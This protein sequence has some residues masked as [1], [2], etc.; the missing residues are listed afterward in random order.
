MLRAAHKS[1]SW[2]DERGMRRLAG[3]MLITAF[4]DLESHSDSRRGE[5]LSWI[6]RND[7]RIFSFEFCCRMLGR[8]PNELRRKVKTES[9][10]ARSTLG[11]R[12]VARRTM[13]K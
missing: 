2:N 6:S 10:S 13:P 3:A 11:M 9:Y 4:D 1:E 8:D 5:V 7:G 12:I